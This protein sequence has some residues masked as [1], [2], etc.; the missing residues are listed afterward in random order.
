MLY[1]SLFGE[2]FVKVK[3]RDIYASLRLYFA[4]GY[5]SNLLGRDWIEQL[6]LSSMSL[7]KICQHSAVLS[8]CL[9]NKSK[10]RVTFSA[11]NKGHCENSQKSLNLES[12]FESY[13]MI[14]NEELGQCTTAKAHLYLKP[15]AVLVFCKARPITFAAKEAVENEIDRLVSLNVLQPVDYSEWAAPIVIVKKPG[16]QIRFCGDFSTGLNKKLNIHKYPLPTADQIF[17]SL[18]GGE[19]FSTTD[20]SEAYFQIELDDKSKNILVINT[21][22]GLYRFNRLAFG[23]ASAPAIYQKVMDQMFSGL[24]GVAWYLVVMSDTCTL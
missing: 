18:Q 10:K 20:F 8:V 16:G 15:S 21:H 4:E 22:K 17:S 11:E 19:Y 9:T 13:K 1:I 3:F 14:F 23:V 2:R 5:T 7:Q 6:N 24:K 12:L